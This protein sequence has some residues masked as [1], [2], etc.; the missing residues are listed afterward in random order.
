VTPPQTEPEASPPGSPTPIEGA[1][2]TA[3]L[4]IRVF[5]VW[6][7]VN[8]PPVQNWHCACP[9][10][11]LCSSPGKHPIPKNWQ[12]EATTK[13]PVIEAM[14]KRFPG[15]NWG[16]RTDDLI[17]IDIDPRSG[18]TPAKLMQAA[19]NLPVTA[20]HVRTGGSGWHLGF[21][22]PDREMV[23]GGNEALGPGLDLKARGG[24]VVCVGS[25]H[26]SGH[27][28]EWESGQPPALADVPTWAD[29][30][31]RGDRTPPG[32]SGGASGV[33]VSSQQA[34]S[35]NGTSQLSMSEPPRSTLAALL[36]H[37]PDEGS[38][39]NWLTSV[40]GHVYRHFPHDDGAVQLIRTLNE[41]MGTPL[42]D[43]EVDKI[44]GSIA[45]TDG[46]ARD[47]RFLEAVAKRTWSM[48]VQEEAR[49][50]VGRTTW[51]E[52]PQTLPGTDYLLIADEDDPWTIVDLLNA[53]GNALLAAQ[54]KVG[55][56]TLLLNLL[57]SFCD[58][59]P[60]LG[61]F[62]VN[63]ERDRKVGFWNYEMPQGQ[64]RRWVR[65]MNIGRTDRFA[66]ADLRGFDVRLGTQEGDDWAVEWLQRWET[67]VW[68]V[69]PYAR[70]YS[71]DSENDNTEVA[72]FTDAVDRVKERA[73]VD[74]A[75]LGAHFGRA[76]FEAGTEHVRGA[77][78]LDDWADSRWIQTKDLDGD[79]FFSAIGR[80]VD[81]EESRLSFNPKTLSL[82]LIEGNR[83]NRG[84]ERIEGLI[85][86]YVRESVD[87][88]TPGSEGL[89]RA[90]SGRSIVASVEGKDSAIRAALR[91][92]ERRGALTSVPG[93]G[94][95]T[96]HTVPE[97][98][99][100]ELWN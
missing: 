81:I 63:L 8:T 22:P 31:S 87:T 90:L 89:K 24:F 43:S 45:S 86:T 34:G 15:C 4:G 58:N 79:R 97:A 28:Y 92:L 72:R 2:A 98:G 17:V 42:Q 75:I 26:F 67:Q 93:P 57:K 32:E 65:R 40:A 74:I 21:L 94:N 25:V 27:R 1:K 3:A 76:L 60:F 73:G 51:R 7:V 64:F 33:S 66:I 78:R 39:N 36:A 5:P 6:G 16:M 49:R 91:E 50:E 69:D 82:N 44:L 70:A 46:E 20:W 61:R 95:T 12:G 54:F 62:P 38:R 13:L 11:E 80:D 18:G 52:P 10:A 55:K 56:T 88:F 37:P 29:P 99:N 14:G 47:A 83:G 23:K 96:W 53:G 68:I 71:G 35:P 84:Q 85:M 48:R 9:D 59:R 19:P 77:T 41:I 30:R 100:V